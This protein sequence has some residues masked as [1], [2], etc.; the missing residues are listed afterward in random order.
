L[1]QDEQRDIRI[2][3][4]AEANRAGL[5]AFLDEAYGPAKREFLLTHGDWWHRGPGG[6]FVALCDGEVAG[7]RGIIP[8]VCLFDGRELPAV[9]GMDLYV[10]PRFRGLGLQ[11]LLDQR[12]LEASNLRMSFPGE[13]GAKIY[14][15]QGYSI[16]EDPQGL[17][18][19]L[20]SAP[21]TNGAA[22]PRGLVRHAVSRARAVGLREA[23]RR[24]VARGRAISFRAQTLRYR[25]GHTEII[26]SPDPDELERLFF[27][28]VNRDL[29]TTL[30][31]AEFLRWRYLE[32]PYRSE[33]A[34]Y[35][36]DTHGRATHCAI[37]RYISTGIPRARIL[38]VFGDL[39]DEEGLSD[40]I[41]TVF[42]DAME[43]GLH[44]VSVLGS[45]QG[46]LRSLQ[47]EG[48]TWSHLMRFRWLS[49]IPEVQERFSTIKLHWVLGDSD[50]DAPPS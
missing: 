21:L 25:P 45:S 26:D 22:G 15:K 5:S 13:L 49:D 11:R 23:T 37:V 14:A 6:R 46:F 27:R 33:L 1:G 12:L 4:A 9:W 19:S 7:Y 34:F 17:H 16:R 48:F 3:E 24:A 31:S 8:T 29:A 32:A 50:M 10:L 47:R 44:Y 38:D 35:I 36:T 42:R 30:R 43:R 39:E 2:I 28:Y 40:L 20:A 41:R 18:V